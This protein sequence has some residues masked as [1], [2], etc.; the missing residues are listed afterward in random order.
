MDCKPKSDSPA[1]RQVMMPNDTNGQGAIFGGVILSLID[2]A[3]YVEALR[4]HDGRY[5]TVAF[6]KVEFHK[7]V[8]V[9]DVVSLYA[10]TLRIGRTSIS[11]HVEVFVKRRGVESETKVTEGDVV[12]VHLDESGEPVPFPGG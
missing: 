6:D 8:C 10:D 3:A 4:Q 5:A 11:V 1:V 7:P 9:D 12:L 2:L